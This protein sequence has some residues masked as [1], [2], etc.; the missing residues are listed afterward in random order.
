[1]ICYAR[2]CEEKGN[3]FRDETILQFGD[4][5]QLVANIILLNPGS[6]MPKKL[7]L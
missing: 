5:W 6:A 1:M 3:Q 7:E 4:G 2:W